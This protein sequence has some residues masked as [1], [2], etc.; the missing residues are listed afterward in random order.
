MEHA[1]VTRFVP[2]LSE[3]FARQRLTDF[4]M[5]EGKHDAG[6][7][8]V[9]FLDEHN[10]GRSQMATALLDS[11]GEGRVVAWSGGRVPTADVD[12]NV[13]AAMREIGIEIRREYPKPWTPEVLAAADRIVLMGTELAGADVRTPIVSWDVPDP[14]GRSIDAV[15]S[16]RDDIRGRVTDLLA[17]VTPRAS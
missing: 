6:I 7:P 3:W 2:L 16:I 4:A 15:R 13:L 1:R 10:A 9:V 17:T 12:E 5:V 14:L 11:L 8:A